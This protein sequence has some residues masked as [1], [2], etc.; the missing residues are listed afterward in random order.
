MLAT[1]PMDQIY[2]IVVRTG[3][4][5]VI[6][7][8]DAYST[9]GVSDLV[10]LPT[11]HLTILLVFPSCQRVH[12]LYSQPTVVKVGLEPNT[13]Q[14]G[15][16]NL[17]TSLVQRVMDSS[18]FRT[19]DHPALRPLDYLPHFT[20]LMDWLPYGSGGFLLFQDSVV[21]AGI[22]PAA[23]GFSVHCSTY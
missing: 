11:R 4:E 16:D 6:S 2:F 10:R 23:R 8:L 20:R 15:L 13:V 7:H 3:I 1:T 19:W 12:S 18:V 5:P 17:I 14:D 9:I 22:E 21:R